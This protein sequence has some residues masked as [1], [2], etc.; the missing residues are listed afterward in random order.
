MLISQAL[1]TIALRN[2]A[3]HAFKYL[4]F[5]VTYKD[6]WETSSR[7]SYFLQKEIGHGQRV[8][9]WMSNCPHVAY[10]FIAL[11][12]TRSCTVPLNPW[13]SPEENL[14]KIKNSGI[15]TILCTSDHTKGLK[16]FLQQNGHGSIKVID[17]EGKRCAE[18]DASY[19]PPAN[20]P[21]NEKDPILIF[22]TPGTTGKYK[23]CVFSH[24]AVVQ[25]MSGVKSSYK[26]SMT[27]V[28]YTQRHYSN[29][30]DFIHF[31]LTPLY[32]ASTVYISD[33]I[34]YKTVLQSLT[35]FRVTRFA[36]TINTLPELLRASEA[37]KIPVPTLRNISVNGTGLSKETFELIK[38]NTKANAVNV[39]GLTEY[40]GTV[41]MGT[42]EV[43]ADA[44]KPGLIGPPIVG[45]K[46]RVVDD[47][48]DEIDKKKPQRG[49]IL[50]TGPC[51]MDKYLDLPEEQKQAVRGTWLFTGDVV[52][53]DQN[54]NVVFLD[55]KADIITLGDGRKF[56]AREIEPFIKIVPQVED[57]AY[58]GVRDRLKKPV[59]ALVVV[60]K[61]QA[62]LSEKQLQDYLVTKIPK[63][64]LPTNIFFIDAMPKTVSG[65]I[66]RAKLRSL[67][68][69]A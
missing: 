40:L 21:P 63:E 22:Y 1:S 15:T 6:F 16:E 57:A 42:P 18:Y 24:N 48:N 25:S 38:K 47:N 52:D 10:C 28:F 61:A 20:Q 51:L 64:K 67:Y 11:T 17:M 7:F 58:V 27:D 45:T 9:L 49:Q 14:Y 60:K 65:A 37:E 13:A 19:T 59:S 35:E 46:I 8:G 32:A 66:N 68:D 3:R 23:G 30:F 34:D 33:Q 29:P 12:N 2:G 31:L 44:A 56:F 36:P 50:V 62:T 41:A 69:G 5:S 54:G 53:L 4:K 39:Y 43:S 55:R 26:A